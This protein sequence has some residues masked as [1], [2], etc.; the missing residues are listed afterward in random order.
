MNLSTPALIF[1]FLLTSIFLQPVDYI[2]AYVKSRKIG[3]MV[4]LGGSITVCTLFI[5][6]F[7]TNFGYQIKTFSDKIQK[8]DLKQFKDKSLI[9]KGC[10]NKSVPEDAYVQLIIKLQPVVKSLFY[11]EACSSVPLFKKKK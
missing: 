11:G 6:S 9:I 7:L 8:I 2:E 5:G 3:V 1:S 4:V 10:S